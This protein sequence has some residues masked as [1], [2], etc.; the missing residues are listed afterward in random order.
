[1][2][3][4]PKISEDLSSLYRES[5]L[6][7]QLPQTFFLT[8]PQNHAEKLTHPLSSDQREDHAKQLK[9]TK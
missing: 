3:K 9:V 4:R 6:K 8:Q 2:R 5:P 1:M 7:M